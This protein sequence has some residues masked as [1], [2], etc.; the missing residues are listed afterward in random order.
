MC[1]P[2]E[3][4]LTSLPLLSEFVLFLESTDLRLEDI[5][6]ESPSDSEPGGALSDWDLVFLLYTLLSCSV[7]LEVSPS[8]PEEAVGFLRLVVTFVSEASM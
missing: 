1:E 6:T 3:D 7:L 2:E 4:F 8:F 5:G